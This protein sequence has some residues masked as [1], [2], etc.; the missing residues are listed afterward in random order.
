MSCGYAT[1]TGPAI[2]ILEVFVKT[3]TKTPNSIIRTCKK[4]LQRYEQ[5]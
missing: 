5:G 2:V 1:L 4:R 3:T